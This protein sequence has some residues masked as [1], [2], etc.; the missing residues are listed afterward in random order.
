MQGIT[1]S[2]FHYQF[3]YNKKDPNF[4]KKP[5]ETKHQKSSVHVYVA[6]AFLRPHSESEALIDPKNTYYKGALWS[7]QSR[8]LTK[9]CVSPWNWTEYLQSRFFWSLKPAL[10]PSMFTCA[11]PSSSSLHLLQGSSETIGMSV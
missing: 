11:E 1:F 4:D 7:I 6:L 5:S 3:K 2:W 9:T 8:L 10:F